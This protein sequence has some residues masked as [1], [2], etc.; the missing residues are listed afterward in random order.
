MRIGRS[1]QYLFLVAIDNTGEIRDSRPYLQDGLPHRRFKLHIFRHFRP[2]THQAHIPLEHIEKLRQLIKLV[3]S[4][5]SAGIRDAVIARHRDDAAAA[6][7]EHCAKF[8]DAERP[9]VSAHSRLPEED[10]WTIVT[11][12]QQ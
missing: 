2:G 7:T 5:R 4:E 10:W 9:A 6:V 12:N 1:S 3:F 8:P 11:D